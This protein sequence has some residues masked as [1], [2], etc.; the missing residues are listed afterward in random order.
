MWWKYTQL[1]ASAHWNVCYC[2]ENFWS[3]D[4]NNFCHSFETAFIFP[5][6]ICKCLKFNVILMARRWWGDNHPFWY[7]PSK[8]IKAS[9]Y[10]PAMNAIS[11]A[12]HGGPIAAQHC[13]LTW[14][15]EIRKPLLFQ[16]LTNTESRAIAACTM[17][18]GST[19]LT[20]TTSTPIILS[21]NTL[22]RV[23]QRMSLGQLWEIIW[24]VMQPWALSTT[25]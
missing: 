4:Q 16:A 8:H 18:C 12:F 23:F 25:Q 1:L 9:H 10:R 19:I 22:E 24:K 21:R 11:M 13:M 15:T 5:C 20:A 3:G 2:A 17:T 14:F 7:A 6:H